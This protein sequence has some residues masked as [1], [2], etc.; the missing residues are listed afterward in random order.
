[1]EKTF[2][3]TQDQAYALEQTY[4]HAMTREKELMKDLDAKERLVMDL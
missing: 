3:H 2:R 1:M 4:G